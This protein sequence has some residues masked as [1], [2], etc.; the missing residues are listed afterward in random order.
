MKVECSTSQD[1][2]VWGVGNSHQEEQWVQKRLMEE[3]G[4]GTGPR[5]EGSKVDIHVMVG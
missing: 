3:E 1:L 5:A 2:R 4:A